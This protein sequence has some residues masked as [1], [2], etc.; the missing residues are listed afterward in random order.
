M[1]AHPPSSE[2][3]NAAGDPLID[4]VLASEPL[5]TAPADLY[6]RVMAGVQKQPAQ[7][8][9]HIFNWTELIASLA[10]SGLAVGIYLVGQAVLFPPTHL[11]AKELAW[12]SNWMAMIN[13]TIG[14]WILL[15]LFITAVL[16]GVFYAWPRHNVRLVIVRR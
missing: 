7:S 11:P 10:F 6:A 2:L 15:G 12:F 1:N 16:G 9:F 14:A 4:A 13:S 8:E 3:S 5:A